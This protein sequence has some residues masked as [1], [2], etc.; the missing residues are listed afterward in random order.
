[1]ELDNLGAAHASTLGPTPPGTTIDV[2]VLN[3][4]MPTATHFTAGG[5][6]WK[7]EQASGDGGMTPQKRSQ[8][9]H[10]FSSFGKSEP[11]ARICPVTKLFSKFQIKGELG[12]DASSAHVARARVSAR[13]GIDMVLQMLRLVPIVGVNELHSAWHARFDAAIGE[14][15]PHVSCYGSCKGDA[16]FWRRAQRL[17]IRQ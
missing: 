8:V 1:M 10:R 2:G 11:P 13:Q 15:L 3:I 5:Q 12:F 17:H 9:E 4:G 16:L 14:Q 6:R 7:V